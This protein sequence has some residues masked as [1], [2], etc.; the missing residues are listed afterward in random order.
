MSKLVS[1][2]RHDGTQVLNKRYM[3]DLIP[4]VWCSKIG[5]VIANK[6]RPRTTS[7]STYLG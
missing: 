4:M 2:E 7:A 6:Q 3:E 5:G 1:K